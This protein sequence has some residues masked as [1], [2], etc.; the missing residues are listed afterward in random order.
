[1]INDVFSIIFHH[2]VFVR[3]L[4]WQFMGCWRILQIYESADRPLTLELLLDNASQD[5]GGAA[6]SRPIYTQIMETGPKTL[7]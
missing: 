2:R 6:L 3:N 1:M 5:N 4:A 7:L